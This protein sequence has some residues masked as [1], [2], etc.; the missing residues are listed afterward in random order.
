MKKKLI[1]ILLVAVVVIAGALYFLVIRPGGG[2]EPVVYTEY[3]PGDFFVDNVKDTS[4]LFKINMVLVVDSEKIIDDMSKANNRIRDTIHLTLRSLDLDMLTDV[5]QTDDIKRLIAD[6]VNKRLEITNVV[7]V[8]F[9]EF[10]V[11]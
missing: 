1:P 11:Q 2:E 10:V 9:T 3:S 8:Y 5:E 7:D 6:A 4:Y